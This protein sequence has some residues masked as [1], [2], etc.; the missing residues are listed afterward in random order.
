MK[1]K[2]RASELVRTRLE[3]GVTLL[4]VEDRRAPI[5]SLHVTVR[6]G[7]IHEG[8]WLGTGISH[9]LEHVID[10]GTAKRSREEIDDLVETL[11]NV[12]NAYT[13]RDHSRYFVTAPSDHA[14][15][16][17]DLLSDFIQSPSLPDS[18]VE[19]Q[20]GVILNELNQ[21]ADNPDDRLG[22]MFYE[23]VYRVHPM[24]VPIEG[25]RHRFMTLTRDDLAEYHRR[26][27]VPQNIV[28]SVVGDL[29]IART[30]RRLGSLWGRMEPAAWLPP[31]IPTEPAQVGAR[32]DVR[33]GPVEL[34]YGIIGY[35]A[36]PFG[37]QSSAALFLAALALGGSESSMLYQELKESREAAHSVNAWTEMQPSSDSL[38][39]VSF[40]ADPSQMDTVLDGVLE[41]ME[42]LSRDGINQAALETARAI[43]EAEAL[44]RSET[45]EDEAATLGYHE[46]L[47]GDAHYNERFLDRVRAV[48]AD[49]V[50]CAVAS[51]RDESRTYVALVPKTTSRPRAPRVRP[52]NGIAKASLHRLDNGLRIV[53]QEDR[54]RPIAFVGAFFAGGV[55][56]ETSLTNGVSR[57]TAHG[58]L[59]GTRTRALAAIA[60]AV[61]SRGGILE[62]VSGNQS[63][64]FGMSLLSRD[65]PDGMTILADVAREPTFDER[66]IEALKRETLAIIRS[67]SEDAFDVAYRRLIAEF[68][69]HHPYRH[70]P[71]GSPESIQSLTAD[72]CRRFHSRFVQPNNGVVSV[73]GDVDTDDVLSQLERL[74]GRWQSGPMPDARTLMPRRS[75]EIRLFE[76]RDMAQ[77]ILCVGYPGVAFLHPDADALHVLQAALA[78]LNYPGGRLYKELRGSQLVYE[79]S[80]E[81]QAGIDTG[82]LHIYAAT[83]DEQLPRVVAALDETVE[84]LR[85]NGLSDEEFERV[86]R[87]CLADF[88]VHLQTNEERAY[89]R[90][91]DEL[92]GLG[93]NFIEGFTGRVY[94]VTPDD[95]QRAAQTYL[96][97]N[98]RVVSIVGKTPSRR[99]AARNV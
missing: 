49:E 61:E 59:R 87:M 12:S 42:R 81:H 30:Q 11:G 41:S 78:G 83:T 29:D 10:D 79:V 97:R 6:A 73:V 17:F 92:Y 45:I 5:F 50:R 48:T 82:M 37:H 2:S 38:L 27:Y 15:V 18:D 32:E 4:L 99:R 8:E 31:A 74:F 34:G 85:R 86:R 3:N 20:R 89:R 56:R 75:R 63:V 58:A 28:V 84:D 21:V 46:L 23:N 96:R 62:A 76:R 90:G 88:F 39:G 67:A 69:A 14:D 22:R 35:R 70:V 72:D 95:V 36:Q 19:T 65:L 53:V 1:R 13:A 40:S 26:T 33:E 68:F 24:R 77:T 47:T 71:E 43:A 91:L 66:E 9:F 98:E 54:S 44:F 57:L 52:A 93:Y 55:Y 7:T 25:Y 80:A 60:R 94:A 51:L 16:A 64:G